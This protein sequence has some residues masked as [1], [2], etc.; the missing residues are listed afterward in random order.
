MPQQGAYYRQVGRA[1]TPATTTARTSGRRP[2]PRRHHHAR[3]RRR[4][5]HDRGPERQVG[6]GRGRLQRA[7]C[8]TP[9]RRRRRGRRWA[10]TWP[11]R[12]SSPPTSCR[13]SARPSTKARGRRRRHRPR[14]SEVAGVIVLG[15]LALALALWSSPARDPSG[16]RARRAL[17]AQGPDPQ[18]LLRR[19]RVLPSPP[20]W[21]AA[22]LLLAFL[23]KDF[24]FAYV[25]ENS[26][27]SLSV[28]YRI[29]GF[30]AGQQ[31]SFLL[32]LLLLA[33]VTS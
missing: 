15:R 11:R 32:W 27:A 3:R 17:A 25:A 7:R 21:R 10:S 8:R 29:S 16:S 2:R 28:F 26:D 1:R 6:H 22:V 33:V 30:W 31:G 19:L 24:S 9:S 18:R 20:W 13:R 4:A 12:A 14:S 5:L 23:K